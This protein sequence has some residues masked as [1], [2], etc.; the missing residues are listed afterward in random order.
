LARLL[1]SRRTTG[2]NGVFPGLYDWKTRFAGIEGIRSMGI[3]SS[4]EQVETED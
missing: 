2:A 4:T 1:D 3:K